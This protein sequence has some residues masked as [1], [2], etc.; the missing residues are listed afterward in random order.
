MLE[1]M[2]K[3]RKLPSF[4]EREKMLKVLLEEEY[5]FLPPVPDNIRFEETEPFIPNFCA[6]KAISKKTQIISKWGKKEFSFPCYVSIPKKEG[7]HPFFVC[8]NFRDN[9]PDRYIP[10]EEIID[11]GFGVISFCYQD[12]T[13]DSD[14]FTDGLAGVLYENGV[15]GKCDAGKIAMWAWAAHRVMDYAQTLDN[16][17]LNCSTVCGH[18][19]LGKTALL[20]AATDERFQFA[21]SNDSGCCGAAISRGKIGE[22]VK[23]ICNVFPF[24]FCERFLKYKECEE[25]MPFDQ[26]YLLAS[27]APRHVYIASALEDTWADPD[28]E[29]LSCV[30]VSEVFEKYGKTGFVCEDRLPQAGDTYHEGTVGYHL[31]E[32]LHY[33]GREDWLKAMKYIKKH[34]K[35]HE[36]C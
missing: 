29:M 27:I 13:S 1:T 25:T 3:E 14:D 15:R 7:K 21:Y 22:S 2:L 23:R 18:S 4:L 12:V 34:R 28:S 35:T 11:N 8:I 31:R 9:V 33:F 20:A 5:G 26:H 6:G 30:V 17:D 32:G 19:R 24:W 10:V 36:E 16:L